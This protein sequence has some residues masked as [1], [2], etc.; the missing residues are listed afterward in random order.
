MRPA[1][2]V[3][4]SSRPDRALCRAHFW[5]AYLVDFDLARVAAVVTPVLQYHTPVRG[6]SMTYSTTLAQ[7][8]P[9][10]ATRDRTVGLG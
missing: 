9:P 2:P 1:V 7:W 5:N 3:S 6:D 10:F 8:P 4:H